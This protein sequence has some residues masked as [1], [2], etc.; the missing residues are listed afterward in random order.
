MNNIRDIKA[1]MGFFVN[2]I[3]VDSISKVITVI[4]SV[5]D[6]VRSFLVNA[7]YMAYIIMR[8]VTTDATKIPVA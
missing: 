5:L 1:K 2:A 4:R 7:M 6:V 3:I 8:M